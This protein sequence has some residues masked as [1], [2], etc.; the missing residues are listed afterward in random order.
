MRRGYSSSSRKAS[1]LRPPM[2]DAALIVGRDLSPEA[3]E[4]AEAE[5]WTRHARMHPATAAEYEARVTPPDK[6]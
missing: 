5:G 6:T 3:L 1:D 2:P 4:L